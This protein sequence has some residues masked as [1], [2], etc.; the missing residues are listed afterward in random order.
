KITMHNSGTTTWVRDPLD[1]QFFALTSQNPSANE[2]WGPNVVKV[3][4]SNVLPGEDAVFE[5]PI[6]APTVPGSYQ[7]QWRMAQN[8]VEWFGSFTPAVSV[9]VVPPTGFQCISPPLNYGGTP[10]VIQGWDGR[11]HAFVLSAPSGG[12]FNLELG[13]V[14]ASVQASP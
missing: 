11:L 4:A 6:T 14:T 2:T 5:I 13:R 7:F 3:P 1:E 10:A 8:D 12:W 9:E